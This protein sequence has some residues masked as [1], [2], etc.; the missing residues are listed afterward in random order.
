MKSKI[1]YTVILLVALFS[2]NLNAKTPVENLKKN[3]YNSLKHDNEGVA[4]SAIFVSIQFKNRFPNEND[5]KFIDVLEELSIESKNSRL[6]YKAQLA[7]IYFTNM[8]WFKNIEI[9]SIEDEQKIFEE[10][11]ETISNKMFVADF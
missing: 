7:K 11:A 4:E 5:S 10:I 1:L 2:L 6:S 9:K 3:C 8:D